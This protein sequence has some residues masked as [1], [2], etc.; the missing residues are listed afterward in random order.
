MK[1]LF[2]VVLV[3]TL[4]ACEQVTKLNAGGSKSNAVVVD[5]NAVSKA[6]GYDD[7]INQE[8]K[9]VN[10]NLTKQLQAITVDL[11]KQLATHKENF[12]KAISI[13]QQQ[14]LQEL[15]IKA[16]QQLELKQVEANQKSAQHKESLVLAWREKLQPR[17]QAIANDKGANVVLVQSPLLMWFDTAIDITAD[18]VADLRRNPLSQAA[19]VE[20]ITGDKKTDAKDAAIEKLMSLPATSDDII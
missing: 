16:N 20:G 10:E 4:V 19:I 7:V 11:N 13:E 3:L 15:L 12:G 8:M 6:T 18:V 14:Q 1:F 2:G 5:L 17:V 9:A